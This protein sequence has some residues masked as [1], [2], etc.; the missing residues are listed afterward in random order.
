[1][2]IGQMIWS[3]G[4]LAAFLENVRAAAEHGYT[5]AWTPQIVGADPLT[6]LAVAGRETPT[7]QLGTAVLPS[8]PRHPNILAAQALTVQALTGNRLILGIGTSHKMLVEGFWGYSFERPARHMREYLE[9]LL[10]LLRGEAVNYQ[11]ATLKAALPLPL[12]IPDASA[13]PV[14][15]AALAPAMLR[16]AGS[17]ADG[18]ITW[19]T[20]IKTIAGHIVPSINAAAAAAGRPAPRV[21]AGLSFCVTPDEAAARE[22]LAREAAMYGDIPSYRAMLDRE[23]VAGPADIAIVGDEEAV[24]QAMRQLAEAGATEILASVFG[25]DEEIAR[26]AA[27]LPTLAATI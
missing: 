27:L 22:R 1:M 11:G 26:T 15:L 2:R 21:V 6:A 18:T 19:Q 9:A 20:G 4:S 24:A 23:G 13:P 7:I 5:T 12:A 3:M 17:V 25:T 14:L 8:Y 10:P 16:L